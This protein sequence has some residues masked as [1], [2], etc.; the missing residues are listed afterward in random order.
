MPIDYTPPV[1]N[2][3]VYVYQMKGYSSSNKFLIASENANNPI[4][5]Y[6]ME[7]DSNTTNNVINDFDEKPEESTTTNIQTNSQSDSLKNDRA[8]DESSNAN[9]IDKTIITGGTE[10]QLDKEFNPQAIWGPIASRL[11]PD[12]KHTLAKVV[13]RNI[14]NMSKSEYEKMREFMEYI[15]TH[16]ESKAR[17]FELTGFNDRDLEFAEPYFKKYNTRKFFS[18]LVEIALSTSSHGKVSKQVSGLVQFIFETQEINGQPVSDEFKFLFLRGLPNLAE[19]GWQQF[20]TDCQN[21][22]GVCTSEYKAFLD[23]NEDKALND[24][25]LQLAQSSLNWLKAK[26]LY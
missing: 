7:L 21:K 18:K 5:V 15:A 12:T 2:P 20:A 17:V 14:S 4:S 16:P 13:S 1:Q 25:D 3:A 24:Q 11:I 6:E 22:N 19:S 23:L 26:G 9:G 8:K 10:Y